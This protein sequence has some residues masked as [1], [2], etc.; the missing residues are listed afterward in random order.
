M[1]DHKYKQYLLW[2][3][4]EESD[5]LDTLCQ[6]SGLSKASL[7]RRLILSNPIRERPNVDFLRLTDEINQ[8]GVNF[9]QLVR[10]VNTTG[11]AS[12][13]DLREAKRTNQ[14]V[15]RLMREWEKTWW[16]VNYQIERRV[17]AVNASPQSFFVE[18]PNYLCWIY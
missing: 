14:Q 16:R 4:K 1:S 3:N 11:V 15:Y 10:K 5:T 12:E 2:M 18:N 8:I 17:S 6:K 7:L 13:S 9:N